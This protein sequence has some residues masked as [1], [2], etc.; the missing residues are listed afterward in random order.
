MRY[1]I[2]LLAAAA[3]FAAPATLRAQDDC[4][5][6]Y[7]VEYYEERPTGGFFGFESDHSDSSLRIGA[8]GQFRANR[9][10]VDMDQR[11]VVRVKG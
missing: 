6:D 8:L 3:L 2:A 9:I 5:C 11:T 1:T 7:E 4:D 10:R